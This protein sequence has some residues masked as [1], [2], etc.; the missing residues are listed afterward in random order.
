MSSYT[1]VAHV[2]RT[3][4]LEGSVVCHGPDGLPFRM[5]TGM[6]VHFVPPT[7]RGPRT[8]VVADIDELDDQ[9]W[10]VRFEGVDTIDD[11]ELI[12]GCTCL[13]AASDV[14]DIPSTHPFEHMIG[15]TLI[16]AHAGPVG[17][18]VEVRPAPAQSLLVVR[19][20]DGEVL[21]PAVDA[22]IGRV[23]EDARTVH[24]TLPTG[25]LEL[26]RGQS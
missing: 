16:E 21:V 11:A 6:R 12:C 19:V 9:S 26:G 1:R 25:L 14:P 13:A 23:D 18:I 2:I 20:E 15:C 8:A 22:F 3:K 24:A 10:L 5:R 4:N 17:T 7:L